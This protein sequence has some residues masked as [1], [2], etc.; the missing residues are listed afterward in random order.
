LIFKGAV[1]KHEWRDEK[2]FLFAEVTLKGSDRWKG[3]SLRSWIK[4]E[5]IFA[6]ID[7]NPAVMPPDLIIFLDENGYGITNDM[8]KQGLQVSVLAA[9][10]PDV[11]RLPKGLEFFGPKHFGFDQ[12]YVPVEELVR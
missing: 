1:E 2:G 6:W 10:A 11:W 9:K 12:S 3:K 4:N 8:L 7:E 5:H